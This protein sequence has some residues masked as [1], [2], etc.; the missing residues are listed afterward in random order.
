MTTADIIAK[1]TAQSEQI[2]ALTTR[3]DAA[4]K[5][6][7]K[8]P[9]AIAKADAASARADAAEKA[10]ATEKARADALAAEVATAKATAEQ[11]KADAAGIEGKITASLGALGIRPAAAPAATGEH[12]PAAPKAKTPGELFIEARN[13]K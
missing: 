3:L 2:T 1:L 13:A 7:A 12:T 8:L 4:E 9:D 11:A 6:A 10:V 5:A